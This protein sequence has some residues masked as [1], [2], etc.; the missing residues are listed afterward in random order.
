MVGLLWVFGFFFFFRLWSVGV[1]QWWCWGLVW[2][3]FVVEMVVGS[4][5]V[6]VCYRFFACGF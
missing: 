6:V 3:G 4:D 5:G 1:L 2:G